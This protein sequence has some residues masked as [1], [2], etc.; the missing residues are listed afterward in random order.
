MSLLLFTI[1]VFVPLQSASAQDHQHSAVDKRGDHV[2]GFS[3]EKT[4]HHFLL[5][6]DGGA[7]EVTANS[8]D[9]TASR[10]QIRSHL[11]HIATMFAAGNFA[12]PML[13]HGKDVPGTAAMSQLR[14]KINYRCEK[15][16]GGARIQISTGDAKALD[17]IHEFL[18]F[19]IS[20]HG[21]GD[22]TKI[23]Q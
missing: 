8:A 2:M 7:I 19:Q 11:G 3:H 13:V 6:K 22:S 20:D 4:T 5:H 23:A 17:A 21:T 10:D 9:D 16:D 12:A 18:R 15:I 14:E 1:L